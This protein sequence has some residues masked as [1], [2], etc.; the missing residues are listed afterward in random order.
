M[1]NY[2]DKP[3]FCECETKYLDVDYRHLMA[4]W[5][6][7]S[8]PVMILL[9]GIWIGVVALKTHL[10]TTEQIPGSWKNICHKQPLKTIKSWDPHWAAASLNFS[11]QGICCWGA[12][13][14]GAESLMRCAVIGSERFSPQTQRP[15]AC[16]QVWR[17]VSTSCESCGSTVKGGGSEWQ[18]SATADLLFAL[19]ACL[20]DN[21]YGKWHVTFSDCL[22]DTSQPTR[23]AHAR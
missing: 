6:L 16:R 18:G 8:G 17:G 21:S 7:H 9:Y 10:K 3:Q 23:H 1:Y 12:N 14:K 19:F 4:G 11:A 2:V 15:L 22:L 5:I 20:P 13:S